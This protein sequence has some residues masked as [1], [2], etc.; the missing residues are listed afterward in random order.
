M[1]RTLGFFTILMLLILIIRAS[2]SDD[3]R[4]TTDKI[5]FWLNGDGEQEQERAGGLSDEADS[6]LM[7]ESGR[8]AHVPVNVHSF[9]AVGDG[10]ADD[11]MAFRNAWDKACSLKNA[12][13]LVPEQHRYKVNATNFRGP[14]QRHLIVQVLVLFLG[15]LCNA[16]YGA[17]TT[18]VPCHIVWNSMSNWETTKLRDMTQPCSRA[19]AVSSGAFARQGAKNICRRTRPRVA[20]CAAAGAGKVCLFHQEEAGLGFKM[21]VTP[22]I[23]ISDGNLVVYGKTILTGVPDNIV[24]TGGTGAG[25]MAG[26]FIGAAA[27]DSKSLHVFPMGTLR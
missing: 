8:V 23:T 17:I 15:T 26:A 12:V 21:T 16:L 25:L 5:Q 14:C 18:V 22:R 1:G 24:L 4:F 3:E 7:L 2:S 6:I 9:G 11:T 20:R 13:L 19:A 27:S 10:V